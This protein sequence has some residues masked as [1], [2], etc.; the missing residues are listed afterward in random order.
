MFA[1]KS[2]LTVFAVAFVFLAG[3]CAVCEEAGRDISTTPGKVRG[4]KGDIRG[5]RDEAHAAK[6][7]KC[8]DVILLPVMPVKIKG[9][10]GD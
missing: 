8:N 10:I 1:V 5:G 9:E 6:K 2:K 4:A 7:K 3:G